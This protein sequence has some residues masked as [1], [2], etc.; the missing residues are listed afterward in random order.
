M[1]AVSSLCFYSLLSRKDLYV[2]KQTLGTT[3]PGTSGWNNGYRLQIVGI[4]AHLDTYP[5]MLFILYI[6]Q[7][8]GNV[9][10]VM[11]SVY[12][13]VLPQTIDNNSSVWQHPS[14]CTHIC[15]IWLWHALPGGSYITLPPLGS[16]RSWVKGSRG[17]K[18]R[19][20]YFLQ[21]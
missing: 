8:P 16:F 21:M 9:R 12:R 13:V 7:L 11:L 1:L 20:K 10:I 4:A 2:L 5:L 15:T 19:E 14:H 3:G 6:R 17:L 18:H